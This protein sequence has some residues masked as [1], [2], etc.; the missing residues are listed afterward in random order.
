MV[1]ALGIFIKKGDN[2]FRTEAYI[3]WGNSDNIIGSVLMLNPGSAKLESKTFENNSPTHGEIIIDPTMKSLIKLVE[4]FHYGIENLEGR[5]YIY[6]LFPLQNTHNDDAVKKFQL[7]WNQNEG[8]VK[9]FPKERELLLEQFRKSPWIL[10]GWGCGKSTNNLNLV[11]NKWM[12]L[13]EESGVPV[14]GK[15]GKGKLNFYHPRPHIQ[16]QQIEYRNEIKEQY[17]R[18]LKNDYYKE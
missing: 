12:K 1:K 5:L 7:L 3:Q 10:V 8:L 15:M 9:S 14:I 4:E 6:N 11:K 13:I 18:L 16:S 17:N 2:I